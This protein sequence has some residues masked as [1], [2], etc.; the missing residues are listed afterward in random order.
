MRVIYPAGNDVVDLCAPD[1][2]RSAANPKY[3]RR[4]LSD[5]EWEHYAASDRRAPL[6]WL[7]WSAKEAAYKTLS[8]DGSLVFAQREFRAEPAHWGEL[9]APAGHA[10]GVVHYQ[11]TTIPVRWSWTADYAHSVCANDMNLV[12]SAVRVADDD[13]HAGAASSRYAH[14]PL[15]SRH[16]RAL[17]HEMLENMMEVPGGLW[18]SRRSRHAPELILADEKWSHAALSLSHDGRFVAAAVSQCASR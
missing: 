4:V 7:L 16:A 1:N 8:R 15:L 3:A 11:D 14:M 17:A 10:S 13:V 9:D 6:L 2:R 12:R 18:I 5:S